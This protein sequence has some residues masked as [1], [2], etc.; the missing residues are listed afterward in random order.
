MK[1]KLFSLVSKGNLVG[2]TTVHG[3]W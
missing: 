2:E 1:N 3:F